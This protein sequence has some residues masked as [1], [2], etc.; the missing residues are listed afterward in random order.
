MKAQ[1]GVGRLPGG[2]LTD[3]KVTNFVSLGPP[4]QGLGFETDLSAMDMVCSNYP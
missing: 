2:V 4:I 1:D 3:R